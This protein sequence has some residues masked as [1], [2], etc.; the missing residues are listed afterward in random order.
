MRVGWLSPSEDRAIAYSGSDNKI[1][2]VQLRYCRP[3][4]L[5][6]RYG[7]TLCSTSLL[8][9]VASSDPILTVSAE[10]C[11]VQARIVLYA[12]RAR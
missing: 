6:G 1:S 9:C 8:G 2:L 10:K 12:T 7:K 4:S 11:E 3:P 5:M